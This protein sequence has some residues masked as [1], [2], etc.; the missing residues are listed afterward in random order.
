MPSINDIIAIIIPA[1]PRVN[2]VTKRYITPCLPL[3]K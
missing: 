3:P 1:I 2:T